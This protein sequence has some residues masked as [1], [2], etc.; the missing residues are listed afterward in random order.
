MPYIFF[1]GPLGIPCFAF[2][3]IL[4]PPSKSSA[5]VGTRPGAHGGGAARGE[6]GLQ[7]L[8]GLRRGTGERPLHVRPGRPE[9]GAAPTHATRAND[10]STRRGVG[11]GGNWQEFYKAT[12]LNGGGCKTDPGCPSYRGRGWL[13][14][15]VAAALDQRRRRSPGTFFFSP[16][17]THIQGLTFRGVRVTFGGGQPKSGTPDQSHKWPSQ[18]ASFLL[19]VV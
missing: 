12:T 19:E 6:R 5:R 10:A 16:R 11:G 18:R 2:L 15:G 9:R 3:P 8:V 7:D 13:V 14:G 17:E 1:R 4:R